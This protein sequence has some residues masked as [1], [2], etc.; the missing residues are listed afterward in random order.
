MTCRRCAQV[1][2]EQQPDVAAVA[3]HATVAEQAAEAL[4]DDRPIPL[5]V[6]QHEASHV[7]TAHVVGGQ[8]LVEVVARPDSGS[9]WHVSPFEGSDDPAALRDRVLRAIV[10]MLAGGVVD[11]RNGLGWPCS[12]RDVLLADR[13]L[14]LI[15]HDGGHDTALDPLRR[16][17]REIVRDAWQPLIQPLSLVLQAQRR[18]AGAGVTAFLE[19]S[20]EAQG[21]RWFY[22]R[23]FASRTIS[24]QPVDVPGATG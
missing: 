2:A 13:F 19:G 6:A 23:A 24:G 8:H 5:A 11:E 16:M 10:G 1:L 12:R 21:L 22:G 17:A 15:G 18:L 4:A 9:T 20:S 7:V 14:A 3:Q